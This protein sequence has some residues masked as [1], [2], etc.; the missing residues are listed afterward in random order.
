[1]HVKKLP[2]IE[3]QKD[4]EALEKSAEDL[5]AM[6]AGRADRLK[7]IEKE[8][9]QYELK[10]ADL[11]L[12]TEQSAEKTKDLRLKIAQSEQNIKELIEK[13]NQTEKAGLELR[14]GER[15]Q[16]AQREK[17]GGELAR[18]TERKEVMLKEY[19]EVIRKLYDEYE[20]TRSEAEKI[21]I[22]I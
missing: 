18:L 17:I 21:G 2:V 1:M 11:S 6:I 16:T 22:H 20:L 7:G 3:L 8:I 9:A 19:D 10:N 14:T 12:K 5:R 4:A 15:E 13:R